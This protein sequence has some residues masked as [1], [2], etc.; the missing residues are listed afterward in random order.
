[1]APKDPIVKNILYAT[2]YSQHSVAALQ[3]AYSFSQKFD[4][5]LVI[6]HVFDLPVIPASPVSVTYLKKESRSILDHQARLKNFCEVHLGDAYDPNRI[7]ITVD[8]DGSV[9]S[10]ILNKA[11]EYNADLIVVGTRGSSPV[12]EFILGSTS[13]GL[14]GQAIS[15]VLAVPPYSKPE[16]LKTIAYATDFEEADIAAIQKL[17]KIAAAYRAH[18]QVVHIS[19]KNEYAGDQQMEWFKEMLQEKAEYEKMEFELIFSEQIAME[20]N[21]Y[22]IA[23]EADLLVMLERKGDSLLSKIFEGDM[24]K[25]M[26]ETITIPLLSYSSY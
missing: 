18:I 15:P 1:M 16:M 23:A 8:E 10:G 22:L 24:V 4:A 25:K 17:I 12:R 2:D 13:K 21:R 20:L 6:V 19:N 14:V 3:Y 26:G 7:R 11:M 9:V 5:Q